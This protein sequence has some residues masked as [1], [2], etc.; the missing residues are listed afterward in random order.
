MTDPRPTPA[1]RREF[2]RTGATLGG[3][4]AL[5]GA[6]RAQ[7]RDAQV[8]AAR[9]RADDALDAALERLHAHLPDA[10]LHR[11][12]HVPMVIEALC[13][14]GH[15]EAV[16]PWFEE[17]RDRTHR[18][19]PGPRPIVAELWRE[20]LGAEERFADWHA[21]FL[22]E[23]GADDWKP[24][25]R[26][27]APR[28][29][30]GLAGSATHGIIRSAHATRALVARDN[31]IRRRELATGLAYWAAS[32]EEL[33][34][35]GTLAPEPSVEA[36]LARVQPRRPALAPPAG[37][38]VTGLRALQATSSFAPVAGLVDVR[39]PAR[40]LGE[41]TAASARAYLRNPEHRIP[42][43][44]AVTAPSALRLL[45][46]Y[47]D[48]ECVVRATRFAWQAAAGLYV[49]YGDP[50]G[51]LPAA[52]ASA[53]R[54]ATIARAIENG[55]AHAIKL[56][57]ASLREHASAPDPIWAQVAGDAAESMAG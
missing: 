16:A 21:L 26:R 44:H 8:S 1:S 53:G 31:A 9:T 17:H 12:N 10:S 39:D 3:A 34:W 11:S 42:F 7:E 55:G 25:V 51:A 18:T 15:G 29:V 33:P 38:I 37:N 19:P 46:P 40:T 30:P 24:V 4:F 50:R 52:P 56:T 57:E 5:G 22:A 23:L 27:W 14:L 36:A 41:I 54:E 47:L 28:L 32:Y 13:V 48:E 49:V 43:T 2:L 6:V 45:A 35:D 20:S